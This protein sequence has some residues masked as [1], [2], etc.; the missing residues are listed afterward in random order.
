MKQS[1]VKDFLILGQKRSL[2]LFI[3][4]QLIYSTKCTHTSYEYLLITHG[5]PTQ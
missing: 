1:V 4:N 5:M 3:Q 2:S